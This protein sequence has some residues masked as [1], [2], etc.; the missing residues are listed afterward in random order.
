M[1]GRFALF[2]TLDELIEHFHL[3]AGFSMRPR[4]NIAP[5]QIIPAMLKKNRPIDFCRWGFVPSW[6]RETANPPAGHINARLETLAEKPTFRLAFSKNRCLIPAS[7][8]YEWR[9]IGGKKQPYFIQLKSADLFA[10]AGVW[11]AWQSPQGL[12][13]TCAILTMPASSQLQQLHA[14][15]PVILSPEHYTAWLTLDNNPDALKEFCQ[16]ASSLPLTIHP[17]T[18]RMNNPQFE[19][20]ECIQAL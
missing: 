2:A 6:L 20:K 14:R 16:R 7:G 1:C 12:L 13:Q 17:V 4:Y 9:E 3:P 5:H 10:F 11:S 15:M 18:W 19:G 8:Y